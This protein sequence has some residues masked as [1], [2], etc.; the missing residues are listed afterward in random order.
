MNTTR[1]I[2][3]AVAGV[4]LLGIAA[5][6]LDVPDLNNPGLD[7]LQDKPD[8]VAVSKACTGL[9]IGDRVNIAGEFGY[10]DYLGIL[11][12]EAYNFDTAD[13]RLV[14]E[15]I[16]GTLNK[17]S[18]FGGG[19]WAGP[20]GNIWLANQIVHALDKVPA[21]GLNAADK[22][23]VRGFVHTIIALN[24]LQVIV[25]HD[26]NGAVIETDHTL[27]EPL[28][29]IASKPMV[30]A[31]I[32]KLLDDAVGELD[33]G[34]NAFPF[35]LSS[36]FA[37]FDIPHP[38]MDHPTS[39]RM[40]NRAIKAR[41]AAYLASEAPPASKM[42][43]YQAVLDALAMSFIDDDTTA[44]RTP[45]F[46]LGVYYTY[47][48]KTG[49]ATNGLINPNLFAHPS[50][51]TDAAKGADN[52]P[53][54][55]FTRKVV[56]VTDPDEQGSSGETDNPLESDLKFSPLYSGPE[57]PVGLIRNEELILLKAEALFFTAGAH[58]AN[59]ELNIVRQG[60]GKLGPA[61]ETTD[62]AT[63]VAQLLYER[64]YSLLFESGHRW[65]DLRRFGQKLPL[66][67][68]TDKPNVRF[69][70]PLAE[71]VARPNEL[72]CMGGST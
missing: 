28:G 19:I 11:G 18:P 42:T 43:A 10:V 61:P 38:I 5:C 44:G 37:G 54:D 45:N 29:A 21:E 40:F 30:Y 58:N 22:S 9:L 50:L 65:I 48:T 27:G 4:L 57:S 56:K 39:F 68:P 63:F 33:A 23:A 62:P 59:I 17:G 6:D 51:E 34:G 7:L 41:V 25:T 67:R 60:S 3:P 16:A 2:V 14:S 72:A 31:T 26:T 15:M 20:Y 52:K 53:D 69:P 47:S 49:D 32:V 46:D 55:R 1:L 12:R 70:I 36:G 64:R 35:L 8:R 24:L 13:P 66:D 71:C